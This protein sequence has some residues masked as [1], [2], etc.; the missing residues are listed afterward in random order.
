M[1][2]HIPIVDLRSFRRTLYLIH[3]VVVLLAVAPL[4]IIL[5]VTVS[6]NAAMASYGL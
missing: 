6:A 3:M 2:V 1:C 4:C 5:V